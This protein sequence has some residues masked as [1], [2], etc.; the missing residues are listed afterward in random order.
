MNTRTFAGAVLLG[1]ASVAL[2]QSPGNDAGAAGRGARDGSS[3][4]DGA[5]TGGS[6]APGESAGMP[7]DRPTDRAK[8]RCGDLRGTLR[9]QCLKQEQ[10]A[11]SG[12]TRAPEPDVVRPPSPREAPPPQNPR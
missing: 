10:G 8:N 2:A 9:E 4:A 1:L 11:S 7:S 3:P 6:I 5:I 12:G